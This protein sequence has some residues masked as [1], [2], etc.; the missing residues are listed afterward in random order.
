[1]GVG[2]T[3]ADCVKTLLTNAPILALFDPN[4]DTILSVDASSF[5]LGTVLLPRQPSD[6]WKPV[7]YISRSMTLMEQLYAQIEKETLAF[8]WAC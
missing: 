3:T 4:L 2:R 1:M 8:I 5:G 6:E 7:A